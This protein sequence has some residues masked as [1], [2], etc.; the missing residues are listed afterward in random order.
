MEEYDLPGFFRRARLESVYSDMRRSRH[1]AV[2]SKG[3]SVIAVGYNQR[4]S[5]PLTSSYTL[6]AEVA[7]IISR[8]FCD[9]LDGCT[10]WV[11]RATKDGKPAMSKPCRNCM[12]V[13][14]AAGISKIYYT[15]STPPYYEVIT[16]R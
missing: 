16:L 13:I 3:G 6:H 10:I 1:G 8:R 4:K 11:Y 15:I 12:R 5:H 14:H 2:I 9:A 7:A